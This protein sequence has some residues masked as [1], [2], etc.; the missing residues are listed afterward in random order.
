MTTALIMLAATAAY[1][2]VTIPLAILIGKW[3]QRGRK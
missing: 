1:F 3:I 2:A